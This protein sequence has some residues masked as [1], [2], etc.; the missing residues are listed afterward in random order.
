VVLDCWPAKTVPM[1]ATAIIAATETAAA[2]HTSPAFVNVPLLRWEEISAIAASQ[3][4]TIASVSRGHRAYGRT[5]V[6]GASILRW[7]LE[8]SGHNV[9][10]YELSLVSPSSRRRSTAFLGM[11]CR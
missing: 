6:A 9:S 8:G 1:P 2:M 7:I 10:E 3:S 5:D 4:A 11:A